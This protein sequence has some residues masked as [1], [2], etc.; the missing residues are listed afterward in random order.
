MIPTSLGMQWI[1][2]WVFN[3]S[4]I[5]I[6]WNSAELLDNLTYELSVSRYNKFFNQKFN[7]IIESMWVKLTKDT[8][9]IFLWEY[10]HRCVNN[11]LDVM[12]ERLGYSWTDNFY[13]TYDNL[14]LQK[15]SDF[16]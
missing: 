5:S 16:I 7:S 11:V 9:F 2:A 8:K 4:E 10:R 13:I 3:A 1:N 14:T 12:K 6:Y 15:P